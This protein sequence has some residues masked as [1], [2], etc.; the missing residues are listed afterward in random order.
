M[1]ALR[2]ADLAEVTRGACSTDEIVVM[3]RFM[4]KVREFASLCLSIGELVV[5]YLALYSWG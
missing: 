4:L 3:E 1:Q 5:C 2:L